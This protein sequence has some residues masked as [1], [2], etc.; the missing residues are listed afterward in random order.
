MK[1]GR[2]SA[3]RKALAIAVAIGSALLCAW[4]M[5]S[6]ASAS[7]SQDQ[8]LGRAPSLRCNGRSFS[9]QAMKKA[10]TPPPACSFPAGRLSA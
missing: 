1:K 3:A 10:A 5:N 8:R 6:A 7:S 4:P 9:A 2:I